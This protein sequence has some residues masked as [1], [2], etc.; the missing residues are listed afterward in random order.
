MSVTGAPFCM[1]CRHK[2]VKSRAGG[3]RK[4]LPYNK[5]RTLERIE[6]HYRQNPPGQAGSIGLDESTHQHRE[7]DHP[8]C[9]SDRL[10]GGQGGTGRTLLMFGIAMA[11]TSGQSV[12]GMRRPR[13]RKPLTCMFV[14]VLRSASPCNV[15]V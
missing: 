14:P 8:R 10:A 12:L 5:Q 1:E 15:W 13:K 9:G 3:Q 7:N 6:D 4:P 11:L 2:A